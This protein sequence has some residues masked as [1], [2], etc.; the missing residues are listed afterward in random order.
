MSYKLDYRPSE[1]V[2]S[3]L[4]QVEVEDGIV[5]SAAITDGCMG[6]TFAIGKLA[7]GMKAEDVVRRLEGIKCGGKETS[8]PDQFARAVKEALE[9]D[10]EP[11]GNTH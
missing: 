4:I 10:K 6:N 3:T 11:L 5:V 7:V 8:C 1:E 9:K 2:C